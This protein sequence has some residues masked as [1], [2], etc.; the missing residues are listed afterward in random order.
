MRSQ[1]TKAIIL[2]KKNFGEF[3]KLLF[4]YT[5]E[6]GKLKVIAKGSRKITSK[7]TGHIETLNLCDVGI[8]FGPKNIILTEIATLKTF[9]N[10]QENLEKLVPALK[11][12]E[13]TNRLIFENQKFE[14]LLELLLKTLQKINAS[15]KSEIIAEKYLLKLLTMTG[16]LPE[17][18]QQS[19][20]ISEIFSLNF[21]N[22]VD[23]LELIDK[24]RKDTW[25]A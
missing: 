15:P 10:L 1:K 17:E 6:F 16:H 2:G 18:N 5:E 20:R 23:L 3:H 8:Y 19:L 4:L 12:G 11:I 24:V 22:P 7:F 21:N 25:I 9:R 14:G 13:I